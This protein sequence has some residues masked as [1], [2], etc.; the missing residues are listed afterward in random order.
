MYYRKAL[1]LQA[2][3]DMAEEDG[4]LSYINRKKHI[5]HLQKEIVNLLFV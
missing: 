2:F 5:I 4:N 1:V 3:L